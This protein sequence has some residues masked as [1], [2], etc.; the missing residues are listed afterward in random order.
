MELGIE[1][2]LFLEGRGEETIRFSMPD[3]ILVV[4]QGVLQGET[5]QPVPYK[6]LV[7]GMMTAQAGLKNASFP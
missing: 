7:Q 4:V 5:P 2:M 3:A 6:G 1:T